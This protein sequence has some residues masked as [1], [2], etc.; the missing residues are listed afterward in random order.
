MKATVADAAPA[1]NAV[2][3]PPFSPAMVLERNRNVRTDSGSVGYTGHHNGTLMENGNK[4]SHVD[5]ILIGRSNLKFRQCYVIPVP[6]CCTGRLPAV[7]YNDTSSFYS[8]HNSCLVGP[9]G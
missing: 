5:V 2:T 3:V 1:R 6:C 9:V 7:Q 4:A 8:R